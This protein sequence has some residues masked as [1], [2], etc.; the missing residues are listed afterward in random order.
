MQIEVN[1][2]IPNFYLFDKHIILRRIIDWALLNITVSLDSLLCF[3]KLMFPYNYKLLLTIK[4]VYLCVFH[5]PVY[6][7]YILLNSFSCLI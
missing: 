2:I 7:S 5:L 1:Q 3:N 4:Y 6:D